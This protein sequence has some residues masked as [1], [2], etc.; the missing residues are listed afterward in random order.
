ML[1]PFAAVSTVMHRMHVAKVMA[2]KR[3]KAIIAEN[4]DDLV[5]MNSLG[6]ELFCRRKQVVCNEIIY[7]IVFVDS[8]FEP[9]GGNRACFIQPG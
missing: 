3:L 9:L 5:D 1:G 8:R 4:D 2:E 6:M 7:R